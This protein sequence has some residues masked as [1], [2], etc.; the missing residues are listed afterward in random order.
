MSENHE[1]P[2]CAENRVKR[3]LD[4]LGYF[5]LRNDSTGIITDYM[6]EMNKNREIP[7]SSCPEYVYDLFYG[8]G[9]GDVTQAQ[10]EAMNNL[11]S[12]LDEHVKPKKLKKKSTP[13]EQRR[14]RKESFEAAF[15]PLS[16]QYPIVDTEGNFEIK[17]GDQ[18]IKMHISDKCRQYAPKKIKDD[19]L[20]DMDHVIV[21]YVKDESNFRYY[22]FDQNF[23]SIDMYVSADNSRSNF[24]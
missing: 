11:N 18:K 10:K 9:Q 7:V 20:Y 14:I 5:L 8:N 3:F 17:C 23:E 4:G 13:Y 12:Y 19:I 1:E 22:F 21:A 24:E 6:D 15:S 16:Y 2:Y